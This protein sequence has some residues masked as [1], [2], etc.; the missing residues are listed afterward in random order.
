MLNI[1]VVG[2][3]G[4]AKVVVDIIERERKFNIV[5]FCD[6]F[7]SVG[8]ETAGY[9]VL[10]SEQDLP[11]LI[12]KYAIMGAIVAI[13]DNSI[14]LKVTSAIRAICPDLKFVSAIHPSSSIGK[15]VVIGEGTVV[16]A[17]AVVNPHSRVGDFCILNTLSSLDHDSVLGD[18]ASLAPGVRTGGSCRI[19]KLS[20]IGIGAVLVHNICVGEEAVI[21]A[22]ST[23]MK[24]VDS[25]V[26]AYG[27]PA[28]M[29]RKRESGER[30]L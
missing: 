14:R 26:V 30:Y 5:G 2:S 1:I 10:G 19:G 11:D 3:S 18:F 8:E 25:L 9:Q 28:K 23:V 21:G 4:H 27:T 24:D 16:M 20:A 22:G 15:G 7:R 29:I 6:S 17:G 12:S 13:G